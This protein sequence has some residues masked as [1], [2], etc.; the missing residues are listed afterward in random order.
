MTRSE[1][2]LF[3]EDN[4]DV[5]I[6]G[7]AMLET[8]GYEVLHYVTAE[9]GLEAFQ[10]KRFALVLSDINLPGQ[11]NGIDLVTA[12][13]RHKPETPIILATGFSDMAERAAKN[14]TVLQKPYDMRQFRAAIAQVSPNT[15]GQ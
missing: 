10:N 3:I 8:C 7:A 15:R 1:R 6:A 4:E 14:F 11:M 12:I 2:V 13:R 5:A 9:E